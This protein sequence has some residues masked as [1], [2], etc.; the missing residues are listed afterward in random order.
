MIGDVTEL[1]SVVWIPVSCLDTYRVKPVCPLCQNLVTGCD[2]FVYVT[3][4]VKVGD[5]MLS[6][7]F[8]NKLAYILVTV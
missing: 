4:N 6:V 2:Y 8:T 5:S 7:N 1:P 3:D